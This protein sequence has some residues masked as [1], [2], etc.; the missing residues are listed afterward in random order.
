MPDEK[1]VAKPKETY[2]ELALDAMR[3]ILDE[4]TGSEKSLVESE[5]KRIISSP[6][7]KGSVKVV[8]PY[9]YAAAFLSFSGREINEENLSKVMK[10]A[11][12]TPSERIIGLLLSS[13]LR[14]HLPYLYAYYFLLA[15]GK[16]G[17]ASEI[18]NMVDSL[19]IQADKTR[20]NE[21]FAFLASK[22]RQRR[23][24]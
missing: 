19:G 17:S 5:F 23:G 20:I 8:V 21:V 2:G 18:V 10:V 7:V 24:K 12:I 13:N 4:L 9:L 11:D 14:S 22:E 1:K 3:A 15:L 16:H 6:S